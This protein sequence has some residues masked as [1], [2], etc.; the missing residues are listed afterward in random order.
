[1][2]TSRVPLASISGPLA[3]E[4]LG[5]AGHDRDD[6]DLFRPLAQLGG[7]VGLGDRA[8]HLLRRLA[9]R[10][11]RQHVGM[12]ILH[13]LDPAG[14]A[15][16]EHRQGHRLLFD[17][18]RFQPREQFGAFFEDRQVGGE[19]R[20]EHGAEAEAPQRGDHFAGHQR[21]GRI[22]EALA[23]RRPNRRR[24]LHD[25]VVVGLVERLPN[26]FDLIFFGDG[27]DGADGGALAALHAGH[28]F[29]VVV[30]RGADHGVEAAV[31]REQC[32]DALRFEADAHAAAALDALAAVAH[33]GRR[34]GVDPLAGFFAGVLDFA[35]SQFGRQRLQF[36]VFVAVAG[37]AFAVV[38]GEEQFDDRLAGLA[39]L[40]ACW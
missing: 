32:A 19:V 11:V 14:R 3:L 25:H 23:Q 20:V 37:L 29:Q 35:D 39:D 18:G 9:R 16:R 40:A 2:S 12:E 7:V 26:V 1:M 36:A 10:E 34:R 21:A 17:Q 5:R 8:E 30:E 13:E 27:A 6:D 31:L 15:T 28:G 24:G 38:L 22:A 4:L 33:Q